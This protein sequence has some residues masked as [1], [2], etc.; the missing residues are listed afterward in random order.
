M[1]EVIASMVQERLDSED[2]NALVPRLS[3][4]A[5]RKTYGLSLLQVPRE[6]PLGYTYEDL[7]QDAIA[8]VFRGKR[9]W[10]PDK[11]PD[12]YVYLTSVIDSLFNGLLNKADHRYRDPRDPSEI[13]GS[14]EADYNDCFEPLRK[15]IKDAGGDDENLDNVRQGIEDGMSPGEIAEFFGIKVKEVYTLKRK[16]LRRISNK[17]AAH[18][19]NDQWRSI[20]I[21]P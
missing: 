4:Y 19:C 21:K 18:P 2:W 14:H 15:L 1:E 9:K 12:L 8:K 16:L 20:I 6:L 10:N 5:L 3:A 11:N 17:M 7:V 13:K